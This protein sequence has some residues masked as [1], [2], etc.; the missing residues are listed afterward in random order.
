MRYLVLLFLCLIAIIAYVQRVGINSASRPIQHDLELNTEEFGVLGSAFLLGYAVM[1]L[2]AGWLADR[3]GSRNALALYALAWSIVTGLIGLSQGLWSVVALWTIMGM[4]QAGVFPCAAK[5]IGQWFPD[6]QKA[7]ASGF[8]G[9]STMLGTAIASSL[10]ALLLTEVKWTW[11]FIYVLY[12]VAGVA[13]AFSFRAQ[14]PEHHTTD[15]RRVPAMTS[16]DWRRLVASVP[17]WLLCGQQFFRAGAMIFFINWFPKFLRESRELSELAAGVLT[18]WANGGA[19]AGGICGGFFSDWLLR[20]TGWRRASR[21]GI[22]VVGLSSCSVL[23]AAT[24]FVHDV[25]LATLMFT[26]GAFLAAFGGVSGYTVAI[27]FGG[28]RVATVFSTMNMCGNFGAA[29]FA[30]AAGAV[31]ERTG[32]W[33]PA[34][35]MFAAIFVVDATCWALL[36]PQGPLFEDAYA[37]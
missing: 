10:T 16:A 31:V 20:R 35:F 19:L 4:A 18:T 8:L 21:Q 34:L 11:Q 29:L 28:S 23:V 7:M 24:Y 17:M 37:R 5:M 26:V 9:S 33:D 15:Q 13:W 22:A 30:Y 6:T 36:N 3:W 12:G 27:E 32:T 25:E 1:Q 14:V 2:P